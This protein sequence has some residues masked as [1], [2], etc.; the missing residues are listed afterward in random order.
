MASLPAATIPC[1]SWR[2]IR[3]AGK[4]IPIKSGYTKARSIRSRNVHKFA[5]FI[6]KSAGSSPPDRTK[7]DSHAKLSGC[8]KGVSGKFLLILAKN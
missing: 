5:N 3:P 8:F 6:R 7:F 1:G 2:E 4:S